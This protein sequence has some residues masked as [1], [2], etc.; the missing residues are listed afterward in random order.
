M[1]NEKKYMPKSPISKSRKEGR[2]NDRRI[3]TTR[4]T[5]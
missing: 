5:G 2:K 4:N 1:E 3:P